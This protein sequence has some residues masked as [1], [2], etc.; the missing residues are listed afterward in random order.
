VLIIFFI[1][2]KFCSCRI[3]DSTQM[4]MRAY[5]IFTE[6]IWINST[7][8][9]ALNY[10]L[11]DLWFKVNTINQ[12]IKYEK[13][14]LRFSIHRKKWIKMK[15][16]ILLKLENFYIHKLIYFKILLNTTINIRILMT[17]AVIHCIIRVNFQESD[18]AL[19][20]SSIQTQSF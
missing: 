16:I 19:W 12:N 2:A 17:N 8:L 5:S 11:W 14:I 15:I 1:I 10:A 13:K 3:S 18:S 20:T 4:W 6:K 9:M 7:G